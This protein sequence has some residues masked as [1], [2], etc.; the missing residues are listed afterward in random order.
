MLPVG[1]L[2]L[3][4]SVTFDNREGT[5]WYGIEFFR[6]PNPREFARLAR[7]L[8]AVALTVSPA[9]VWG[10]IEYVRDGCN[11]VVLLLS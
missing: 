7:V 8:V 2:L 5:G 3:P 6:L 9:I 4:V 1:E 11:D 10:D